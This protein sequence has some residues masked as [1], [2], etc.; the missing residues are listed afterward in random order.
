V[1]HGAE[2]RRADESHAPRSGRRRSVPRWSTVVVGLA[3][4]ALVA[5]A[6]S[7]SSPSA[8]KKKPPKPAAVSTT[9]SSSTTAPVAASTTTT[10]APSPAA[11]VAHTATTTAPK[12]SATACSTTGGA[13]SATCDTQSPSFKL[14]GAGANSIQPFF[15]RV[16]YYYSQANKGVSVNYSPAGSSVGVT[17]IQQNTV[18]FGDSEIPIPTPATG[19]GGAILQVPVDLG[20][21]ALSYNLPGAA[22]GLKLNGSVLAGIYLGKITTWNDPAISA[23]NPGVSLPSTTIVPVRRADSSGPGYDLDQYLIDTGGSAWTTSKAGTAASTKWP[24]T[25]V[26][27]GEQ[28]NTGVAGFI[29]QTPG[30]IGY[31]EYAYSLQAGFTNAAL[32]NSAGSYVKPSQSS[33]A[34]AGAQATNL[35]ASN[36][37]IVNGAGAGTYPLA[38]FSWTLL[39]QKQTNTTQGVVLGKLLDWV[40]TTGQQQAAALGYSPLPANVVALAHQTLLTLES[41]SGAALF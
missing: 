29:Q 4:V 39:Y 25:T 31:V 41:S 27:V 28:L 38:N 24:I 12:P 14:S 15:T 26:G 5:A 3:S 20:G 1:H 18:N 8:T 34:A 22:A 6:C 17:D 7:S 33:I 32:L 10:A 40:T 13:L 19:T 36:F 16:F 21:V 11:P 9:T 30:A 23:L 37:N 2:T 35:S